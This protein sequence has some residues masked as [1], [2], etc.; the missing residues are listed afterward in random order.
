MAEVWDHWRALWGDI[1]HPGSVVE[2]VTAVFN[3][4]TKKK[5]KKTLSS[6]KMW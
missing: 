1:E 6:L 3:K 5:K 2:L 4:I